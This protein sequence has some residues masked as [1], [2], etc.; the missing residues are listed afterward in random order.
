MSGRGEATKKSF[1]V[2]ILT[3]PISLTFLSFLIGNIELEMARLTTSKNRERIHEGLKKAEQC[4]C[5][6]R[7][8]NERKIK[9]AELVTSFRNLSAD[10][11]D[12]ACIVSLATDFTSHVSR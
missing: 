2:L 11:D 10:S 7:A 4:S 6:V 12:G 9:A 8:E 3:H 1:A 5:R